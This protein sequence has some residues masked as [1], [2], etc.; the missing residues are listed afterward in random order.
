M[1]LGTGWHEVRGICKDD[2]LI[3][4]RELLGSLEI[5][6][7]AQRL[8]TSRGRWRGWKGGN[9]CLHTLAYFLE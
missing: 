7:L 9:R 4:G 2:V 5:T 6:A 8:V 1:I 3:N